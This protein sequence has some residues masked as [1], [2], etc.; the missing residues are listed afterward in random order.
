MYSTYFNF[1]YEECFGTCNPRKTYQTKLKY[2]A[3]IIP[4]LMYGSEYWCLRKGYEKKLPE[5]QD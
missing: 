5:Y 1:C 4:I 2:E 3:F